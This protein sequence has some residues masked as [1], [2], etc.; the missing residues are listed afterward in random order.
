MPERL[1]ELSIYALGALIGILLIW[2]IL[3]ELLIK[4]SSSKEE[5]RELQTKKL[6]EEWLYGNDIKRKVIIQKLKKM[7]SA[8]YLE[9][10]FF[11]L[12]EGSEKEKKEELKVLFELVGIQAELRRILKESSDVI[13]QEKSVLKLGKVGVIY[14]VQ[15]LIDAYRDPEEHSL[16]KQCC[17][18]AIYDL[19]EPL[20]H[21]QEQAMANFGLL[22][23][24]FDIP[25][26]NLRYHLVRTIAASKM[27]VED[28]L[29]HLLKLQND[30]GKESALFVLEQWNHPELCQIVYDYLDDL[31]PH[32]RSIAVS[33]LGKWKDEEAI[34]LL[35]KKLSDPDEMVRLST[36]DV[37]THFKNSA[38]LK[39]LT[40]HLSDPSS[41]V[42]ARLLWALVL[43][44]DQKI[45]DRAIAMLQEMDFQKLFFAQI[46]LKP[47]EESQQVFEFLGVDY[48]LFVKKYGVED[49]GFSA[50][51]STARESQDVA[52]RKRAMMALQLWK[53]KDVISVFNDILNSDPDP[54]NR[55]YA[56]KMLERL[57]MKDVVP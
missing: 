17:V 6:F 1:L 37:L 13:Q 57:K 54:T 3:R 49:H 22:V 41:L 25:N 4:V 27:P 24:L 7:G 14:D 2:A 38:I 50:F 39:Q 33:L 40:L 16:V 12:F 48:R 11:E 43:K 19:V 52:L 47:Q 56:K 29:P 5:K 30:F 45:F 8:A 15:F 55:L 26:E 31:N 46:K 44:K 51:V 21:E 20:F 53:D 9:P 42:R 32:I 28:I 36:V 18:Q 23:Q 10:F 34:L 35:F